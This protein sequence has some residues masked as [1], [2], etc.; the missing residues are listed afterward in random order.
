MPSVIE[1]VEAHCTLGE[2]ANV[3]RGI[4]GEYK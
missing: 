2:I 4:W 3:L 1:A